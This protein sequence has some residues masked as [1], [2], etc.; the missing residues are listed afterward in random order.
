[1]ENDVLTYGPITQ[2][3]FLLNMGI[4]ERVNIL[5]EKADAKQVESLDYSCRMMIDEDK[6]GK[7]FKF[8]SI[9][10]ATLVQILEKYPP[11]GFVN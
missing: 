8:L 4:R 5:K 6:M 3:D 1:M 10:T 11:A 9:L 7:R 2:R